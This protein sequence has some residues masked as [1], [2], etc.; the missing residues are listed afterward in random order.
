M[1]ITVSKEDK[2]RTEETLSLRVDSEKLDI[3]GNLVGE[4]VTVQAQLT[5]Y[6]SK[7]DCPD[8]LRISEEVERLTGELRDNAMSI[9][10]MPVS[11]TFDK[12]KRLVRDLSEE[13]GKKADLKTAGGDTELDKGV[14]EKLNDPVVHIIRNCIEHGIETPESREAAEKPAAGTINLSAVH[15]AGN[16]LIRISDDGAGLDIHAI[17]QKA[18]AKGLISPDTG[19]T[20][21]EIHN[22][23][24]E[25][26]FSTA[27]PVTGISGRGEGMDVVKRSID[28]LRGTIF[29][30][31]A[32][33]EGTIITLK[34]PITRAIIDGL[35]VEVGDDCF[36]VPLSAVEECVK[37]P[38]HAAD[39]AREKQMMTFRE[40]VIP[41][42]S[43]RELLGSEN[44]PPDIE[45]VVIT[46]ANGETIG[47]GVDKLIGQY[48][49]VIK[50]MGKL[51]GDVSGFSGAAIL[52]DGTVAL[53]LDV[54]DLVRS[55]ME[56]VLK[57]N[58]AA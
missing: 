57:D 34:F 52:G 26:G 56:S 13:L 33:G 49:T 16:I 22:L 4:F 55:E 46:E 54:P 23:I 8:L 5:E 45:P 25:P 44:E 20:D 38:R 32:E 53:I 37:I 47:L 58:R 2:K 19:L 12:F 14:I 30:E 24:F 40:K 7:H 9:R 36:V 43:L 29:I 11:I 41:Y 48:Q 1:D 15:S 28:N 21:S 10:M 42:L 6:I 31:S 51:Y 17:R 39:N 50:N 35:L 27:E 3:L 18:L